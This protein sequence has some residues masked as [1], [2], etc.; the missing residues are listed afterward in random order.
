MANKK[1]LVELR[2]NRKAGTT[3]RTIFQCVARGCDGCSVCEPTPVNQ[4]DGCNA[5]HPVNAGNLHI[6]LADEGLP[7]MVCQAYRYSYT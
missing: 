6:S 4:C 2:R 5:G 3:E 7:Y 1:T